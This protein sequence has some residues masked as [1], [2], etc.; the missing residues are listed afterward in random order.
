LHIQE[1]KQL[2]IM[3]EREGR[4]QGGSKEL[5]S[6][7]GNGEEGDNGSTISAKKPHGGG[8]RGMQVADLVYWGKQLGGRKGEITENANAQMSLWDCVSPEK[9]CNVEQ[10][11]LR[12]RVG[13]RSKSFDSDH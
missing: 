6:S 1:Q 4:R 10:Y 3:E 2:I 12:S 9:T 7:T 13:G 8:G 11:Y 5:T